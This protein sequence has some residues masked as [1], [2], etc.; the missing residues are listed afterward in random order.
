M[1][2]VILNVVFMILIVAGILDPSGL[3]HHHRQA[4]GGGA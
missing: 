4:D 1:I 2:M 3:G